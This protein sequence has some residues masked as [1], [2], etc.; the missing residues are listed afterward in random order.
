MAESIETA[1]RELRE[2][3]DEWH[4]KLGDYFFSL[5]ASQGRFYPMDHLAVA[6]L[7]RSVSLTAGFCD[8]VEARN[9]LTAFPLVRLQ[10]DSALR[11]S[12]AWLVPDFDEFVDAML[13]GKRVRDLQDRD[14]ARM[15]DGYLV[16]KLDKDY[17]GLKD[18]YNKVSGYIHLSEQHLLR[19]FDHRSDEPTIHLTIDEQSERISEEMYLM[20]IQNFKAASE[21]VFHYLLLWWRTKDH[22]GS[23]GSALQD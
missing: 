6:A 9:F 14:G 1:L 2:V 12:A 21:I 16:V 23:S 7:Q 18:V 22:G 4:V 3:H 17:P 20:A 11:L 5:T 19:V 13:Q 15:R 8:L 10:L